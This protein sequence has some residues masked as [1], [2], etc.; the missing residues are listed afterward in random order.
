MDAQLVRQKLVDV[1]GNIQALSGLDCPKLTGTTRPANDLPKFDSKMWPVA[2]GMLATALG[3][4]IPNDINIFR[5]KDTK[6]AT[7]IDEAVH[8]VCSLAT[9]PVA[10]AAE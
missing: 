4:T 3:I 10:V 9:S 7:T 5:V 1:L 6:L 8:V 2:T